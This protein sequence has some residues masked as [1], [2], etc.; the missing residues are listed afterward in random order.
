M[1]LKFKAPSGQL[2]HRV[3]AAVFKSQLGNS[4]RGTLRA[5]NV[6]KAADISAVNCRLRLVTFALP[7]LGPGGWCKQGVEKSLVFAA[8]HTWMALY[9]KQTEVYE[10]RAP[11]HWIHDI[12]C[13]CVTAHELTFARN[14]CED[15]GFN[16]WRLTVERYKSP[17]K[18]TDKT[19]IWKSLAGNAKQIEDTDRGCVRAFTATHFHAL[20]QYTLIS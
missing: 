18:M 9:L 13:S 14:Y 11:C 6:R 7:F 5:R 8:L 4:T 19:Q 17:Q 2:F 3:N 12:V 10:T 20:E 15:A 1:R 16:Q